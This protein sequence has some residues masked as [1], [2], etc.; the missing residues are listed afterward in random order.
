MELV[1]VDDSSDLTGLGANVRHPVGDAD[2]VVANLTW[3]QHKSS[4]TGD[5]CVDA[6]FVKEQRVADFNLSGMTVPACF[7]DSYDPL[8]PDVL[9]RKAIRME[10]AAS[11]G[12]IVAILV[13]Y[14]RP[15]FQ[16]GAVPVDDIAMR[17]LNSIVVY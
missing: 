9:S 14:G 12:G 8:Q 11:E 15:G 2:R 17:L 5:P 16:R 13:V 10:V 1:T 3:V 7:Q 6:D 4:I